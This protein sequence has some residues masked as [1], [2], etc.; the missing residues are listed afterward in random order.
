MSNVVARVCDETSGRWV[1]VWV[2]EGCWEN[3]LRDWEWN[4]HL[5]L[6]G[7]WE[8]AGM[9]HDPSIDYTGGLRM[10]L[11]AYEHSGVSFSLG[12]SYPYN[13]PWDSYTA[14]F[15]GITKDKMDRLFNGDKIKTLKYFKDVVNV[16]NA[17]M[18]G[19][20]YGF[21]C[22]DP[23]GDDVESMGGFYDTYD[24]IDGMFKDMAACMPDEYEELAKELSFGKIDPLEVTVTRRVKRKT[25]VV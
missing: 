11:R 16:L 19:N 12:E 23:N 14:G 22:Y 8:N 25:E 17:Y 2:D 15:I 9:E 1:E 18:G 21:S 6:G 13:D 7:E 20:I 3:P 4:C 10:T 24:D 5:E